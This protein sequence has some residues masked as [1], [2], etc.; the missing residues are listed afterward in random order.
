VA[1]NDENDDARAVLGTMPLAAV[2]T[3]AKETTAPS[4]LTLFD[5]EGNVIW[6]AP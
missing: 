6:R 1:L 3:G 5:K 4:A 2:H